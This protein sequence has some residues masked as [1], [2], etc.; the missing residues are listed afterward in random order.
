VCAVY[1]KQGALRLVK[2]EAIYPFNI[3]TVDGSLCIGCGACMA[4]GRQGIM[5]SGCPWDAIRMESRLAT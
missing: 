4:A 5:L 1:C 2:D 3:M